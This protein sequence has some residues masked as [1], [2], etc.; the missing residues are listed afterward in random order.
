MVM[1]IAGWSSVEERVR[2]PGRVDLPQNAD[3]LRSL[4]FADFTL[5]QKGSEP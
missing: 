5:P 1:R 3:R 4:A 2:E